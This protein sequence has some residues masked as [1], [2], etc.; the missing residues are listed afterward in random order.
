MKMSKAEARKELLR[1]KRQCKKCSAEWG[2][3]RSHKCVLFPYRRKLRALKANR[4]K[5]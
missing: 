1:L 5:K 2:S 4:G 3:C